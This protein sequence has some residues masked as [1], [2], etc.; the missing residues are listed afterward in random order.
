MY[1]WLCVQHS[2]EYNVSGAHHMEDIGVRD[3]VKKISRVYIQGR[4][5]KLTID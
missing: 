5:Q 1:F 4:S 3:G 2:N